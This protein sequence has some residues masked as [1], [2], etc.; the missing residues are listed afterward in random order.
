MST[1]GAIQ[2]TTCVIKKGT[3]AGTQIV[4][5]GEF[6]TTFN[7]AVVDITNKSSGGFVELLDGSTTS[8]QV[9]AAGTIVYN[10]DTDFEAIRADAYSGTQDDYTIVY[11]TTGETLSGKFT[12]N[13]MSDAMPTDGN[14]VMTSITFS[15]SGIVTRTPQTA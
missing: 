1:P 12:P 7:G 4:G 5:Q 13:A 11:G 10:S 2:G 14:A 15:S 9:V 8:Q 6:T 3:G